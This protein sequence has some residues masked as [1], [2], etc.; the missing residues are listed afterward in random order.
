M[1]VRQLTRF[2]DAIFRKISR[3]VVN[4]DKRLWDLL[5]DMHDTL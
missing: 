2:D 1:A 5:D 4:F 3:P